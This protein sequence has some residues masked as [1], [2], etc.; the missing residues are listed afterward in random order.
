V[1]IE[2]R[3]SDD[4]PNWRVTDAMHL[5]LLRE[6]GIDVEVRHTLVDTPKAA[7]RLSFRGSP[8]VLTN[9]SD[10][11]SDRKAPVGL[12]CRIYWTEAGPAG[13][14]SE[15]QLRSALGFPR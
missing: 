2:L 4:C 14:P 15:A 12:S 10:P 3:Y 11:L 5:R 6:L 7:E 1:E 9:G 8:T 13:S